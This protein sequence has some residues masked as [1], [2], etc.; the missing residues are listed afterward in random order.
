MSTTQELSRARSLGEAREITAVRACRLAAC[1]EV[2]LCESCACACLV[3]AG[4]GC[5][6]GPGGDLAPVAEAELREDVLDVVFRGAFGDVEQVG[7]LAVG[8]AASDQFGDFVLAPREAAGPGV[9][10]P[11][12][13]GQVTGMGSQ[14]PH[15][16]PG[17]AAGGVVG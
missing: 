4:R 13:L 2:S 5:S 16:E 3:G 6:G 14:A 7:D 17:R 8:E 11:E 12:G 10:R 9:A 1:G 15:A